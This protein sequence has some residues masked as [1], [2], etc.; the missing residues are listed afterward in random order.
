LGIEDC[1]TYN[2]L[3]LE[4]KELPE[5]PEEFYK[6]FTNIENELKVFDKRR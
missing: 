2:E 3:C 5:M 4:Y 1:K 6:H